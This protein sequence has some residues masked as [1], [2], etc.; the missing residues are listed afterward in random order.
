MSLFFLYGLKHRANTALSLFPHSSV[1]VST[2]FYPCSVILHDASPIRTSPILFWSS[3]FGGFPFPFRNSY[4]LIGPV[5]G[6]IYLFFFISWKASSDSRAIFRNT[7]SSDVCNTRM[8]HTHHTHVDHKE[9]HVSHANSTD[10]IQS[11]IRQREKRYIAY[12]VEVDELE[13]AW[14]LR[15]THYIVVHT[16]PHHSPR[17]LSPPPHLFPP[18]GQG[19]SPSSS[20]RL[21]V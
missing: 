12:S 7:S 1:P 8:Y 15:T 14:P 18:L 10:I 16:H 9:Q 11:S 5:L 20:S 4:F 21:K 6:A 19:P 3:G 13:E 17:D 2:Q